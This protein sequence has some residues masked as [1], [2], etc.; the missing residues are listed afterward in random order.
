MDETPERRSERMD[1]TLEP[2]D[3]SRLRTTPLASRQHL[4]GVEDFA[5]LPGPDASFAEVLD[6]LPRILAGRTLRDL[7][8]AIVVARRAGREVVAACGGHVVKVGCGP[9]L[10]DLIA[11]GLVTGLVLNGAAAIHDWE[12]AT[13]GRTSEDVPAGLDA[14]SYGMAEETGAAFAAAAERGAREGIGLGAALAAD[15]A[16]ADPAHG[17][18]SLLVAAHR[19]EVPVTV[20][21]SIGNDTVHAHPAFDGAALGGATGIDFRR[22]CSLVARCGQGVWLNVGSAVVLPELLLKAVAVAR[23]LGNEVPDLTT[24]NLDMLRHYRTGV[25]VLGRFAARGLEITGHHEITL[26]LLRMAILARLEAV[27][28]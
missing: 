12:V 5:R 6:S 27:T 8:D 4:V 11:R 9:V 10:V 26:P 7:A 14:G 23:N 20:H 28:P 13:V 3:L 18:V 2:M 16:E 25:N 21:V 24:A 17:G 22:A 1:E 15:L 19:F